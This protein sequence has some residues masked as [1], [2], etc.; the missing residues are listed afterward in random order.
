[1]KV[2]KVLLKSFAVFLSFTVFFLFLFFPF[3]DL[4]QLVSDQVSKATQNRV[5]LQFQ[6]LSLS[7]FPVGVQLQQVSLDTTTGL[8][9]KLAELV[10]QPSVFGALNKKPFGSVEASGFLNGQVQVKLG[11]GPKS[12]QGNERYQLNLKM[13]NLRLDEAKKWAILPLELQGNLSSELSALADPT[14]KDQPNSDFSFN[15]KNFKIPNSNV[16]LGNLGSINLPELKLRKL[17]GKGR[18]ENSSLVVESL[19]LGQSGDDINGSIKGQIQLNIDNIR[20]DFQKREMIIPRFGAYSFDVRLNISP[21]FE[22]RASL[23]LIFISGYKTQVPGQYNFK[24]SGS[25]LQLPPTITA[26]R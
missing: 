16:N 7:L 20:D 15:V 26:L 21:D 10:L 5:F 4:S 3:N 24:I 6:N 14:F 12:E 8:Q 22:K 13:E 18:L 1:M 17:D 25:N 23:F 9:L 2:L 11:S 19:Q